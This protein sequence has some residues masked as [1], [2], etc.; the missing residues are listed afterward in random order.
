MPNQITAEGIEVKTYQEL[1]DQFSAALEAIYGSDISI[2]SDTPDG[3]WVGN[4]IQEV[5]D[6]EDLLVQIFNNFDP[7]N[8]YGRVLD[9]RVAINGIQRQAGTFSKTNISIV[10][11][12]ACTLYGLDQSDQ[13]I[14]TVQD[15]EGNKWEL[16]TTTVISGATTTVA[17]FQAEFPG[18]LTTIPNTITI[19]Y[20]IVLGVSSVNNPTEQTVVGLNEETDAELKVRRQSSVSLSSQGYLAGLYAAIEN[21]SGVEYVKIYENDTGEEDA[22]GIPSNSIWVIISGNPANSDIA[23]AIYRKRNAGCGLKGDVTYT[24]TQVDGTPFVVRWDTVVTQDLY[25]K[26]DASSLDGV[27]PPNTAAILAQLPTLFVPGVDQQVNINDLAT[28]V[29]QIDSNTLVTNAGF[30]TS[31]LGPFT[32]TLTPDSKKKQ[33]L[34]LEANIDITIV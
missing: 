20:T 31:A 34:V 23:N 2:A 28:I 9:Q 32:N 1:L 22:D 15:A 12:Q 3:Q 19:P 5:L 26:F 10:T 30:S 17:L 4:I 33:F 27:N 14:Y 18:A 8:A 21:V 13:P 29:Q 24:V 16:T 25:I 11:S 7:D 6:S